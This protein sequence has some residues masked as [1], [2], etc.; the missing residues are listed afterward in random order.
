MKVLKEV[1]L[2]YLS[3]GL[4]MVGAG[5][6]LDTV[7]YWDVFQ[8]IPQLFILVCLLFSQ[9]ELAKTQSL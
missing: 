9:I 2:P 1:C 8:N 3:A 6:V 4:G 5:M 7:Q